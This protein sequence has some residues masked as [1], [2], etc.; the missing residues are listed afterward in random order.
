MPD[1]FPENYNA[2]FPSIQTEEDKMLLVYYKAYRANIR[3]K[4]NSLRARDAVNET[5]RRQALDEFTNNCC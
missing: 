4:V 3:A 1:L 5:E 2:L